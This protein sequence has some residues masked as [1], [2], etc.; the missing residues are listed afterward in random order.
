MI[1][2]CFRISRPHRCIA[3]GLFS[4]IIVSGGLTQILFSDFAFNVDN[5]RRRL[6]LASSSGLTGSAGW[7][8][9]VDLKA[10][11]MD[12][13]GPWAVRENQSRK[14]PDES[15]PVRSAGSAVFKKL[16]VPNANGTIDE[17]WLSLSRVRDQKPSVSIVP[18]AYGTDGPFASFPSTSYWA[19]EAHFSNN[20]SSIRKSHVIRSGAGGSHGFAWAKSG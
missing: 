9:R 13:V 2:Y 12:R 11:D 3:P 6:E 17:C 19:G 14:G 4:L 18:Y 1:A 20:E 10:R 16:S 7:P 15:S 5:L 8:M